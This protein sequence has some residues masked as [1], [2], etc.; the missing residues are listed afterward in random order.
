MKAVRG[1]IVRSVDESLTK[2]VGKGELIEVYSSNIWKYTSSADT[3][4]IVKEIIETIEE[5]KNINFLQGRYHR[6][7][8]QNVKNPNCKRYCY[9]YGF[10]YGCG[11]VKV[12]CGFLAASH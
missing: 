5:R 4:K 11:R 3:N 6:R 8:S 1:D 10:G 12:A 9:G 7:L 2:S